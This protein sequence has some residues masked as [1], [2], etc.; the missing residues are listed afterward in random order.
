MAAGLALAS[1][2]A[3]A[4]PSAPGEP[5]GPGAPGEPSAP[6]E[7]APPSTRD[8][9]VAAGRAELASAP[10][11]PRKGLLYGLHAGYH[12]DVAGMLELRVG[13]G[14]GTT[15]ESLYLPTTKMWRIGAAAR[16]AYG[17]HDTLALSL[18]AGRSHVGILG[19]SL[20]AGLD[21]RVIGD[22]DAAFG[23]I[24]SLGL[25]S[26]KLGLHVN[27]WTHFVDGETDWGFSAALGF[28]LKDSVGAGDVMRKR[29]RARL[30]AELPSGVPRP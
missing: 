17:R 2:T 22:G 8:R 21:A 12:G 23:P 20:E 14:T 18:L 10:I 1:G 3:A 11:V 4:Q 30:E 26:G 16:G 7:P 6:G 27:V 19:Y 28:N 15:R 5:G 24:A 9:I 25:R 13:W 29:A